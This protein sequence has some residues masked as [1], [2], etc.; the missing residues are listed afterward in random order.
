[1]IFLRILVFLYICFCRLVALAGVLTYHIDRVGL[2]GR[3]VSAWCKS[4]V[5]SNTYRLLILGGR[6][7]PTASHT[8]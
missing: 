2:V 3:F 4:P 8:S 7:Q 5:Q 1:M 6:I